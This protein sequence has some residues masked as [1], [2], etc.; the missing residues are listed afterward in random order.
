[1]L[2]NVSLSLS[3]VA[4]QISPAKY[5]RQFRLS[6]DIK[7]K[8]TRFYGTWHKMLNKSWNENDYMWSLFIHMDD[9]ITNHIIAMHNII[10]LHRIWYYFSVLLHETRVSPNISLLCFVFVCLHHISWRYVCFLCPCFSGSL[11]WWLANSMIAP[12]PVT[13][14]LKYML[15]I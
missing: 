5:P 6:G 7:T 11:H 1:M 8:S 2:H 4:S 9:H 12:Q 10:G 15:G 13:W 14:T 3:D